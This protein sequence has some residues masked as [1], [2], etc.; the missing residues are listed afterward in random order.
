M[1]HLVRLSYCS[2][3]VLDEP[4]IF[5]HPEMQHIMIQTFR[6]Y[7]TGSMIIATHS[8]ELMNEVDFSHIL[9]IKRGINIS[10]PTPTQ[11]RDRL[12]EIRQDI[13]SSFNL[14][15]SQ[16][17]DVERIIFTENVQDYALLTQ[18]A[19]AFG[20]S[21]RTHNIPIFGLNKWQDCSSYKNAYKMFFAKEPSFSLLLDKDFYPGDY[22]EKISIELLRNGIRTTFTPGHE[23]ENIFLQQDL[24]LSIFPQ[25]LRNLFLDFLNSTYNELHEPTLIKYVQATIKFSPIAKGKEFYTVYEEIKPKFDLIWNDASKRHTLSEGKQLLAKIRQFAKDNANLT[26]STSYLAQ[27]LAE[28]NNLE[29]R[30]LYDY[31]YENKIP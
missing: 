21:V 6:E 4:E 15:A 30:N 22:L 20:S 2:T 12:E 3:I 7:F 5:L 19:K 28:N 14:V 24:L 27:I 10:K 9:H 29:A 16:F 18:I 13:G 1:T 25:Q 26:L 17:E 8:S 31:V 23:F 11:N